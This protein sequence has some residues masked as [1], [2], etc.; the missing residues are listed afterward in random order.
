MAAQWG[1]TAASLQH[2]GYCLARERRVGRKLRK[3][4]ELRAADS[5]IR[6]SRTLAQKDMGGTF[7]R[8]D[9]D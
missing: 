7:A 2:N 1:G 3:P 5:T 9:R 8:D 4:K 6:W